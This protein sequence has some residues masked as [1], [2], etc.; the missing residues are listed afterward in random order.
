MMAN[1]KREFNFGEFALNEGIYEEVEED[2]GMIDIVS[3]D[4]MW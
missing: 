3:L 1:A 4:R 2:D